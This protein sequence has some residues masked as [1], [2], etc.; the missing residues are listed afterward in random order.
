[1]VIY[2]GQQH[3]PEHPFV[4]QYNKQMLPI[5]KSI[6]LKSEN[7]SYDTIH[8]NFTKIVDI[9]KKQKYVINFYEVQQKACCDD[10]IYYISFHT[11]YA[12][13]V[14]HKNNLT[15][16]K[17]H[18]TIYSGIFTKYDEFTTSQSNEFITYKKPEKKYE[19]ILINDCQLTT[20]SVHNKKLSPSY[21]NSFIITTNPTTNHKISFVSLVFYPNSKL[22][23]ITLH[24][25]LFQNN[26]N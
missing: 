8:P 2:L 26:D 4:W 3:L 18:D 25:I 22:A 9:L 12:K 16:E 13:N 14:C 1:M 15:Y 24:D 21:D 6:E 20:I 11:W 10:N 23:C 19:S 5:I 17:I 7:I